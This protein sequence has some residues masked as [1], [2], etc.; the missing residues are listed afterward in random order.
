MEIALELN[1][2][3]SMMSAPAS[4]YCRWMSCDDLRL[5]QIERIVVQAQ[6]SRMIGKFLAAVIGLLEVPRL[7]HRAHGAIE[8]QDALAHPLEQFVANLSGV[9]HELKMLRLANGCGLTS[10]PLN[11]GAGSTWSP[12]NNDS[13]RSETRPGNGAN[14][15]IGNNRGLPEGSTVRKCYW[16]PICRQTFCQQMMIEGQPLCNCTRTLLPN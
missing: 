3:V 9:T 12:F 15:S 14:K 6:I 16:Q 13:S 11:T 7:N 2:F 5:R 10:S 1:V 8:Q 4:R